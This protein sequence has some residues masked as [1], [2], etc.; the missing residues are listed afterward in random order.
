MATAQQNTSP[1]S[2]IAQ[3]GADQPLRLDSGHLMAGH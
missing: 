1:K 2:E 3:F